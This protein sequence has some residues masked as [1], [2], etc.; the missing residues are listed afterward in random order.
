MEP[1]ASAPPTRPARRRGV[2]PFSL[3]QV[4]AA[5]GVV[6][7]A[8]IGLTLATAP[9]GTAT[10]GLP[11]PAASAYLL[12][13]PVPGLRVGDAAPELS[14]TLGDGSTFTLAD[15]DGAPVRLADLRG[16]GVWVNFWASWCPPCQAETPTLREIDERYRDRG[17]SLVAIQVQQTVEDGRSYAERYGLEY[18]IGADVSAAVFRT[19]RVYAL[20]TQFFIDPDGVI[21]AEVNGPLDLEDAARLVEAILPAAGPSPSR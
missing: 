6:V 1:P 21:R 14:G 12:G 16:R 17:L 9:L 13:S 20:P 4:G 8:A 11:D 19:Y 18:T 7:I 2:G 10:P 3:R 5:L 15:L